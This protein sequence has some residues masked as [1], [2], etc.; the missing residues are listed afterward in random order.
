MIASMAQYLAHQFSNH[1]HI[2]PVA[3][4]K[5]EYTKLL[6]LLDL[7]VSYV[8]VSLPPAERLSYYHFSLTYL[9]LFMIESGCRINEALKLS[10]NNILTIGR[11]NL[12]SSKGSEDRIINTMFTAEYMLFCKSRNN[13]PFMFLNYMYV[14][15]AFKELGIYDQFSNNKVKSV[16]HYFRHIHAI[17]L[18]SSNVEDVMIKKELG[19]KSILSTQSYLVHGKKTRKNDFNK[20]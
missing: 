4:S 6:H 19:H 8:S 17:L 16:T 10:S 15:R 13:K 12:H 1:N 5:L 9:I 20:K 11:V 7:S 18:K 3:S 2:N 14:Y